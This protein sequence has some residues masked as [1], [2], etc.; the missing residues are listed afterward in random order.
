MT[1]IAKKHFFLWNFRE[2]PLQKIIHK[3]RKSEI[4]WSFMLSMIV[5]SFFNRAIDSCSLPF[6]R[7]SLPR[8]GIILCA[9]NTLSVERDRKQET[10]KLH[11][12]K[13]NSFKIVQPTQTP[14]LTC[15]Q[16]RHTS[17]L[18]QLKEVFNCFLNCEYKCYQ[19]EIYHRKQLL[20]DC[21]SY[22]KV[23]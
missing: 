11:N 22:N 16:I 4:P 13:K 3:H 7:K 19:F 1:A 6:D 23:R 12:F 9:Q 10:G 2:T 5:M 8:P 18:R 15:N 21:F 14:V 17:G 20:W